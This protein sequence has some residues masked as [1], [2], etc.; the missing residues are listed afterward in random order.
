MRERAGWC[1]F[2]TC[3]LFFP[4][5]YIVWVRRTLNLWTAHSANDV[6]CDSIAAVLEEVRIKEVVL[7][8]WKVFSFIIELYW[9]PF[10]LPFTR[11][12]TKLILFTAVDWSFFCRE[13][14]N[15]LG[16]CSVPYF[17]V[18]MMILSF[19]CIYL[20]GSLLRIGHEM[21]MRSRCLW[22][23]IRKIELHFHEQIKSC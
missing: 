20:K 4:L 17:A 10:T 7:V 1:F 8:Q 18:R 11:L 6:G 5:I 22:V 19:V 16:W 3:E 13:K 2:L 12:R 23:V 15:T 21:R 9:S 14:P